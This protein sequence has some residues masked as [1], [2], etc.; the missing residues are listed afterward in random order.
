[1]INT[2]QNVVTDT[3]A[4]GKGPFGVAISADGQHVYVVNYDDRTI[5]VI[6]TQ[7]IV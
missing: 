7:T 3:V 4:V 6:H 5:S 1:M 2:T